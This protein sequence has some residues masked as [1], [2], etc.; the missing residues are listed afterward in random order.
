MKRNL[1]FL[2]LVVVF[3]GWIGTL[4]ARDAGYVL[5]SYNGATIQTGLWV[6]IG[7]LF[8]IGVIVHYL[9]RLFRF[10]LGAKTKALQW[11]DNKKRRNASILSSKGMIF[12]QEGNFGRAEKFLISGAKE[13]EF[14][15]INFIAAA[16]AADKLG[17]VEK[18]EAYLREA[19]SSNAKASSAV[20]MASAEMAAEREEWQTC[21]DHLGACE[22]NSTSIELKKRALIALE[23]WTGLAE[24]M[25]QI[26]KVQSNSSKSPDRAESLEKTILIE[27]L[28]RGDVSDEIAVKMF[29][30]AADTLRDDED[31]L[32]ILASSLN[33]E[34][35][36]ETILRNALKRTWHPSLLEIYAN[37]GPDTLKK[38]LKTAEKWLQEYV[39]DA[40]L[41][42]SLGQMYEISG[43]REQA[44]LK[45]ER[46]IEIDKNKPASQN[47][48][49]LLAFDGDIEK[50]NEYFQL[51]SNT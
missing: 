15:S 13:S 18:R 39:D 35:E 32:R 11:G 38:R 36:A 16:K 4:I 45:Y 27:Q 34:K 26:K 33:N 8:G 29:K 25:P 40:A 6:M 12:L 7:I 43:D 17:L 51:G 47:L 2:L 41:L 14:P 46:S 48:A 1:L 10:F 23:D 42:F 9:A 49:K 30:K 44:K 37:L 20:K 28:S 5:I 50:S 24:I 21:L 22:K 3:A 31:V 19:L